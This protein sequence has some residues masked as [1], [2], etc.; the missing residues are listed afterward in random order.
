MHCHITLLLLVLL[1]SAAGSSTACAKVYQLTPDGNWYD[2]INGRQLQPG[3]EVVLAP[4]V[5]RDERRLELGHR[6]SAEQPIVIRSS[7]DG[8]AIL[9]RPDA[10]QN[11]INIVGAQYLILRGLEITGGSTGI[12]LMKSSTHACKFVSLESLHIHHVG[13]VAVTANSPGNVY[14]GLVFRRNHIHHT[15]GHG[16]GFY[17]G[18]NNKPDG[19]TDGCMF[20]SVVEWNY[21]HDLKGPNVSQGDG[22]EIK[23]GSY[24]NVVRDNVIHDTN[25]P[26][27]I[28]YGTDGKAPNV[29]ERNV[30][31][32]SGDHGIQAAAEA[33]IRNNIVFDNRSDGI[34]S[35]HHQSAKVGNLQILHNTVVSRR[36]GGVGIRISLSEQDSLAGPV[37]IANNAIYVSEGAYALRVP[38]DGS[39]A[40]TLVVSSNAGVGATDGVSPAGD[41]PAFRRSGQLAAD[42]D[43]HFFPRSGSVLIGA[44][45]PRY[46]VTDD[47]DARLRGESRDVG[48]YRFHPTERPIW[49]I[50]PGFKSRPP[51]KSTN[52]LQIPPPCAAERSCSPLDHD[53]VM[54]STAERTIR[55]HF[56]ASLRPN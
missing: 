32:N 21:I 28:V 38:A 51:V 20:N 4:G 54:Q 29:I 6:G 10:R 37:V 8:P 24:G 22:I 9:H 16:E 19:S 55:H 27:V 45:N 48:A 23:D 26:G 36:P 50:A 53:S 41:H 13:G 12:R 42:L 39:A 2:V 18:V 1:L 3:D 14:E 52:R 25:Y 43:E 7:E 15:A 30:I 44:A 46:S 11:S 40:A 56:G 31:W 47:F 34:H 35:H 17:L 5:Y 49:T 33:V